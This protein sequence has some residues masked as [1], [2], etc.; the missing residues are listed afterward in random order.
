[1]SGHPKSPNQRPDATSRERTRNQ[2]ARTWKE[3][4]EPTPWNAPTGDVSAREP[5]EDLQAFLRMRGV[6]PVGMSRREMAEA[7]QRLRNKEETP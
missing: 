7:V 3:R 6:D 2:D 5:L 1:M 4:F